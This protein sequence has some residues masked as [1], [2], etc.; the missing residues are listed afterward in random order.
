MGEPP[1]KAAFYAPSSHPT[2]MTAPPIPAGFCATG[3]SC[4]PGGTYRWTRIT[5]SAKLTYNRTGCW[6]TVIRLSSAISCS[7]VSST[8]FSL[9]GGVNLVYMRARLLG[10]IKWRSAAPRIAQPEVA[11]GENARDGLEILGW[12]R[13]DGSPRCGLGP[14]RESASRSSRGLSGLGG[15]AGSAVA[16]RCKHTRERRKR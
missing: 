7:I 11:G 5:A 3:Q 6:P 15:R 1:A 14:R 13:Q 16:L 9:L 8:W 2:V 12:D 10:S 4:M